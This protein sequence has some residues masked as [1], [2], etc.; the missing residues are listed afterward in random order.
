MPWDDSLK[1]GW[2][3]SCETDRKFWVIVRTSNDRGLSVSE[4]ITNLV[5]PIVVVLTKLDLLDMML[6]Q[7]LH[8]EG[9]K[10][11]S[12]E[13]AQPELELRRKMFLDKYCT[14][15]LLRVAGGNIPSVAVSSMYHLH[16][17]S[18]FIGLMAWQREAELGWN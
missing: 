12:V 9:T 6:L 15:P 14:Q 18:S 11:E 16:L 17:F 10:F 13:E 5:V 8:E 4:D 2:R 7:T 3:N 1:L